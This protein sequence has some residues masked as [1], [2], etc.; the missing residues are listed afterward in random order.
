MTQPVKPVLR[1][2][3]LKPCPFC[4]AAARLTF[5]AAVECTG[6]PVRRDAP[7]R[8]L[9]RAWPAGVWA[10]GLSLDDNLDRYRAWEARRAAILWNR[11]RE[12]PK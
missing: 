5:G 10:D 7:A 1:P 2:P 11:R 8:A 3:R 12:E 6:C 4:G 9:S